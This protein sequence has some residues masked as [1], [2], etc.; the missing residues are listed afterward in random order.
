[1]I[2]YELH[3]YCF[4]NINILYIYIAFLAYF[5]ETAS[6]NKEERNEKSF[7]QKI[8][9]ERKFQIQIRNISKLKD[10]DILKIKH[11]FNKSF[12]NEETKIISDVLI[13]Y[14]YTLNLLV[15]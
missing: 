1:M 8:E 3:F 15:W 14:L 7:R 13:F 11:N 6:T 9:R 2:I 10:K 4:I 5:I 12:S